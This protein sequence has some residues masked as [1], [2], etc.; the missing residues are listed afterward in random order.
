MRKK[1][2][3]TVQQ[4]VTLERA[5]ASTEP[6]ADS[7]FAGFI[8]FLVHARLRWSDG[9]HVVSEPVLAVD[10]SGKG[11]LEAELYYHK[12]ADRQ[13]AAVKRLL[14]AVCALPGVGGLNWAEKWL[15]NRA[16]MCLSAGREI[17]F[18]PAPI[19]G[20]GW[21]TLPLSSEEGVVWLRELLM[22]KGAEN[23]G[24]HS[25]KVTILSWMCKAGVEKSVRRLAGYHIKAGDRTMSEYGREEHTPV[26][27]LSGLLYCIRKGIFAPDAALANRWMGFTSIKAA[28]EAE[29]GSR[30]DAAAAETG[31]VDGGSTSGVGTDSEGSELF[32]PETAEVSESVRTIGAGLGQSRKPI[33]PNSA[34]ACFRNRVLADPMDGEIE[35]TRCGLLPTANYEKSELHPDEIFRKCEKCFKPKR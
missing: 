14:P 19:V 21:D 2:P 13:K 5:A 12:T 16:A 23:I 35:V 7:I 31:M 26:V 27:M 33:A 3:F 28:L 30:L 25:C 24:S 17:P 32:E 9:Q 4:L 29:G 22:P 15:K 20:G 34:V 8:C 11:T 1:D 18:M 6:T 10:A